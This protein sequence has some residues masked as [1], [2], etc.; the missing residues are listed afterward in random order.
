MK[1]SALTKILEN[2]NVNA[3]GALTNFGMILWNVSDN[4]IDYDE[5]ENIE[6]FIDRTKFEVQL[7]KYFAEF[8]GDEED[9]MLNFDD[10]CEHERF[11]EFNNACWFWDQF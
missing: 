9:L 6:V 11:D 7:T 5:I 1:L 3:S 2:T 4:R 8:T 10:I